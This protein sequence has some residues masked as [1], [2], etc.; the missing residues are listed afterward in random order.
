M[1][2]IFM[3]V[4]VPILAGGWLAY[5]LYMR[6]VE[7]EE[8]SKPKQVSKRLTKTRTELSDWA[9]KMAEYQPP[10]IEKKYGQNDPHQRGN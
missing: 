5:W 2:V 6:K 9:K 4:M 7:K 8:K 3:L 1:Y 10:K